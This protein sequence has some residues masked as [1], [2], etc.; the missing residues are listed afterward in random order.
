MKF[1]DCMTCSFSVEIAVLV[2]PVALVRQ[3]ERQAV[4]ADLVRQDRRILARCAGASVDLTQT[5]LGRAA[6]ALA[7]SRRC[8]FSTDRQDVYDGFSLSG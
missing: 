6:I 5:G 4:A 8:A 3:L 2:V 1:F 7:G